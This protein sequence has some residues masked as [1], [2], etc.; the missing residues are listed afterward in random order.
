[1]KRINDKNTILAQSTLMGWLYPDN[2]IDATNHVISGQIHTIS[3]LW[4]EVKSDGSLDKRDASGDG[5][6]WYYTAANAETM[7]KYTVEQ[8]VNVTGGSITGAETLMSSSSNRAAAIST[9]VTF[10]QD[11]YFTGVDLDLEIFS[12][13]GGSDTTKYGNFKTFCRE[14]GAALH[15]EGFKL[16]VD[17]PAIWNSSTVVTANEWTNRN[18]TNYYT[19]KYE[20]FENFPEVDSLVIMAYDYYT[21]NGFAFDSNASIAPL[22]WMKDCYKFI[23]TKITNPNRLIAGIPNYTI[24][25]DQGAYSGTQ[26]TY[27][28]AKSRTGY[29]GATRHTSSQE[30]KFTDTTPTPD[31]DTYYCD[32]TTLNQK[33]LAAMSCG[34]TRHCIWAL[35]GISKLG[36]NGIE[37]MNNEPRSTPAKTKH[38]VTLTDGATIATDASKSNLFTVTLGGNRTLGNPTNMADGQIMMWEIIQDGTGT[39]T[40]A[41]DTKFTFGTD[42]T[43]PTLTT[44]INKRDYII[45][46]YRAAADKLYVLSVAKGY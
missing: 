21:D 1:M 35:D 39:R 8:Y 27:N 7:R 28:G 30:M 15:K 9:L 11:N 46:Q 6:N 4:Y 31:Q 38:Y 43:S 33:R 3:A 44:T 12:I 32:E 17:G 42:V 41:Y 20:D 10:C 34:I 37:P 22:E 45:A 13:S 29:S 2:T 36:T 25:G 14:L 19:F 26:V 24:Y 23:R 5:S 16:R 18:S 40:L